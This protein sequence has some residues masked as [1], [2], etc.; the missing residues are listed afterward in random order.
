MPA[1]PAA[2][3]LP[4]STLAAR[5]G[6]RIRGDDSLLI[7]GVA[8]LDS[9]GAGQLA[10]FSGA[11]MQVL[12]Q[13]QAAAVLLRESD[14]DVATA[15]TATLPAGLTCWLVDGE[16]RQTF[17]RAIAQLYPLP[18]A[19]SGVSPQASVSDRAHLGS[20][21]AIAPGAV[22]GA[23]AVLGEGC[24]VHAGA[25][26]GAGAQVGAQTV[27]YP[28]V[29]LYPCVTLGARCAVHAGAVLGADGFGYTEGAHGSEKIRQLGGV[30]I[31]DEV[32][33]GAN[34]AIDCGALDDTVI[35]SGV[36]IDN[37]VQI[38]HN[39]RIGAHSIICG[40]V[41][42]A[43]SSVIGRGCVIGGGVGIAGH[44]HIGDGARVAGA[45]VVTRSIP[46]GATFSSVLP[47]MPVAAWRRFV[48]TLR[49][50]TAKR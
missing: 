20:G 49:R 6:G 11:P 42:I 1:P 15:A 34:S 24:V 25:V 5:C 19:A 41:G 4:L 36:K 39:V 12:A 40:N 21:V 8:A 31:G 23:E 17:A 48:A 16:P 29:V 26:V 27:L 28:N 43:G 22:V 35:G 50:H 37:L 10:F 9:A 33:I 47:A 45:S 14:A 38:G 30:R 18:P 2:A 32:E 46:A 13:T 3:P 44:L 7:R